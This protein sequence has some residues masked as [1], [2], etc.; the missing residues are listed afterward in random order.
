MRLL[1]FL[2]PPPATGWMLFWLLRQE[3][4]QQRGGGRESVC[5]SGL[6]ILTTGA[7]ATGS[8]CLNV[9]WWDHLY[10]K[11]VGWCHEPLLLRPHAAGPHGGTLPHSECR[12]HLHTLGRPLR[13]PLAGCALSSGDRMAVFGGVVGGGGTQRAPSCL[14]RSLSPGFGRGSWHSHQVHSKALLLCAP[15]PPQKRLKSTF[16]S[17]GVCCLLFACWHPK[18]DVS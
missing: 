1:S 6:G 16:N 9:V 7:K 4:Q 8:Q 5:H 15:F 12:F 3:S 2:T 17:Q 14:S 10:F 11:M 13:A 18:E